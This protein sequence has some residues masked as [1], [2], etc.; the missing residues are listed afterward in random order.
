MLGWVCMS[1]L[2]LD[3]IKLFDQIAKKF[4][5]ID[6]SPTSAFRLIFAFK[7]RN[8][9]CSSGFLFLVGTVQS[10]CPF[11]FNLHM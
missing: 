3:S 1:G 11:T 5:S 10:F 2:V 8:L 7:L 4:L 9:L 6:V